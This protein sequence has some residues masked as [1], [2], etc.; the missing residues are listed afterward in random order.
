M[1]PVD[2]IDLQVPAGT[3]I[4]TGMGVFQGSIISPILFNVY[5]N[6]LSKT[7]REWRGG[8]NISV[9]KINSLQKRLARTGEVMRR[10]PEGSRQVR[11]PGITLWSV[12]PDTGRMSEVRIAGGDRVAS[13]STRLDTMAG[14]SRQQRTGEC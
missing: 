4:D 5:I 1:S 6:N 9:K 11:A 14:I 10:S 7:L 2:M 13:Y 3:K 8:L 12:G